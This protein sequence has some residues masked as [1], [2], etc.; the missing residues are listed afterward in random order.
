MS[1]V[2]VIGIG[3]TRFTRHE[4]S[5]ITLCEEAVAAAIEDAGIETADV[6]ALYAGHVHGGAVAGERVGAATGLAGIPT[7]NL[8]NACASGTTAVIEAA[9]AIRAGRFDAVVACGF[10]QMSTRKGMIAP[11]DGDYEGALGLVFPAWHALRARMYME[12]YGLTRDQLSLVA[13]KNRANGALNPLSHWREEVTIDDVGESREIA[14][15]LRLLDCCPKSDGAAAVVLG[16][17]RFLE[18]TRRRHG[19]AV[20]IAGV[21]LSSGRAD[22]LYEPL[23]EDITSRTAELA[24][25]EAG[26]RPDDVDFAEVHDCFTIAEGLRVEGLGLAEP[27]TYF[28]TLESDG[29]WLREGETPVNASGGLLAKGHPVGATGVAQVC[30]LVT[31]MR[32][33]AGDRQLARTDVGIAH[34]RGGSVPGT[35]GGSCGVVV[36]T[37]D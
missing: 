16:S 19:R 35:E 12:R 29:R 30:E 32:G 25:R 5:S 28:K 4:A 23:F 27:G 11:S 22:G 33:A 20:A 14:T 37:G 10:E 13:V 1:D 36:C 17:K 21:G 9:Y 15:P 34:T 6:D 3:M 31:Q 8:E 26:I 18:E 24:Y 2:Y 7:L